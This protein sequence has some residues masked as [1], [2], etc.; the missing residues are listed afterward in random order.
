MKD[1]W[2]CTTTTHDDDAR[3]MHSND[4]DMRITHGNDNV[5]TTHGL[6]DEV[7]HCKCDSS[8]CHLWARD[9]CCEHW[10]C[11][12]RIPFWWQWHTSSW[13][14][15]GHTS[16]WLRDYSLSDGDPFGNC[17]CPHTQCFVGAWACSLPPLCCMLHWSKQ[18]W[19]SLWQWWQLHSL[20]AC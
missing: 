11:P 3:T 9:C 12:H 6:S 5:R 17:S 14:Y 16:N 7:N 2:Q 19:H 20:E 10:Q 15:F 1:T 8:S 18:T 4:D 13:E